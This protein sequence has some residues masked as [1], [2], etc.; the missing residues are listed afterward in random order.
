[1]IRPVCRAA[2]ASGLVL[3]VAIAL[4]ER[5]Q[6]RPALRRL[7]VAGPLAL[8]AIQAARL[9][10]GESLL[11]ISIEFAAGLQVLRLLTRRGAAHD[12]QV[13]VLAQK[14]LHCPIRIIRGK[15]IGGR[16]RHRHARAARPGEKT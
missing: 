11:P 1:M 14:C 3:V 13:V 5:L 15:E 9:S 12:Q 16:L 2:T 6:E 10:L 8:F 4:P 7:S